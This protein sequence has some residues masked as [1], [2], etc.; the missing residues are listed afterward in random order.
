[1]TNIFYVTV[2]GKSA[3]E[4]FDTAVNEARKEH[5]TD[6]GASGS[7]AEKQEYMTFIGHVSYDPD[8]TR[9]MAE[10]LMTTPSVV[11][12]MLADGYGPAGCIYIGES[13]YLFFGTSFSSD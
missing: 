1:M 13:E 12:D 2:K 11:R 3:D 8:G 7:I 9:E 10:R 4:A 6:A 5:I